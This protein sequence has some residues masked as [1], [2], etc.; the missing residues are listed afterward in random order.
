MKKELEEIRQELNVL[1][2]TD[3]I[4]K[5]RAGDLDSFMKNLE[6]KK[7]ISGYTKVEA[8]MEDVAKAKHDLDL[9]KDKNLEELTEI[10]EDIEQQLKEKKAKLAP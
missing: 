9:A 1:S 7:G 4:L 2:R 6:R 3:Q 8:R 5:S 10:V